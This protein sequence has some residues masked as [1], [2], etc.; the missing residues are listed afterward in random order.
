MSA[1]EALAFARGGTLLVLDTVTG[2]EGE[3]L[4]RALGWTAVGCVPGY[5]LF[6]DGRPC[7]T[8]FFYKSLVAAP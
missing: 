5:A 6:P 4:H 8:T 3:R 7:D 1:V 2:G